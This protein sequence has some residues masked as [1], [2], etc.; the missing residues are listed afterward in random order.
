MEG[1]EDLDDALFEARTQYDNLRNDLEKQGIKV[2]V[3][4]TDVKNAETALKKLSQYGNVDL[5]N[6]PQISADKMQAA[7]YTDFKD[8]DVA[9]TYTA[10]DFVWRGGKDDGSYVMVHYTPIMPNG[11]V[12]SPEALH[13]YLNETLASRK[14]C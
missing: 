10:S 11:E 14:I 6:R 5:T 13:E 9:T 8:G 1:L 3:D 4:D 2:D 12:L 7:G